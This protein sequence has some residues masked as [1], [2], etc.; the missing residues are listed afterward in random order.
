MGDE[1]CGLEV[2]T[3]VGCVSNTVAGAAV[4]MLPVVVVVVPADVDVDVDVEM[5]VTGGVIL[6]V[7][8]LICVML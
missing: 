7:I 5:S 8:F 4:A 6:D 1:G 3:G 2:G